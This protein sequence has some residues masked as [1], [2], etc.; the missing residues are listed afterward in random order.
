M[1][2]FKSIDNILDFAIKREEESYQ[3]YTEWS[4][5]V[6]P[7]IKPVFQQ[8]AKEE[9]GHKEKLLE[10]KKGKLREFLEKSKEKIADLKIGDYLIDVTPKPDLTFQEAL[11]IAMKREK[12]S[13]KLYENFANRVD[14]ENI[15]NLFLALAQEEAKHKLRIEII[16]DDYIG[17][18]G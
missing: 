15:K 12:V 6:R 5:K 8:L 14:D 3:F 17:P 13:Y 1:E 4:N 9:V 2:E 16:Y 10:V 7:E 11:I 18:E